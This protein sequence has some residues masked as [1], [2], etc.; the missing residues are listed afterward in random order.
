MKLTMDDTASSV[1]PDG[2]YAGL[3][4]TVIQAGVVTVILTFMNETDVDVSVV[5][6]DSRLYLV[7]VTDNT[8]ASVDVTALLGPYQPN[9]PPTVVTKRTR[10][11]I[12]FPVDTSNLTYAG[13]LNFD[14]AKA[15]YQTAFKLN[16]PTHPFVLQAQIPVVAPLPPVAAAPPH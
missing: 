11:S 4:T 1:F 3:D 15:P 12:V 14:P 7:T 16:S 2:F 8:G 13:K 5:W 10:H 6:N 9:Q